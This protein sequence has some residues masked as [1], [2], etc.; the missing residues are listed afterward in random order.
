MGQESSSVE[1]G[2]VEK[3]I[4]VG[5]REVGSKDQKKCKLPTDTKE[6][7]RDERIDPAI[8]FF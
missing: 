8:N 5:R 4:L 7:P 1:P 2:G 6:N 3:T